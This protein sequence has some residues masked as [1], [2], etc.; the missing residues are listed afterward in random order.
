MITHD[1]IDAL[2]VSDARKEMMRRHLADGLCPATIWHGPG[3]QSGTF[4]RKE[5]AH[6]IHEA[7]YGGHTFVQWRGIETTTG[8]FDEPPELEE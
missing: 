7:V 2:Q 6:E 3:H 4:C 1:E 5:G 8:F